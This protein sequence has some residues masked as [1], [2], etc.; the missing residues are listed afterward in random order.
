M[1]NKNQRLKE[2]SCLKKLLNDNCVKNKRDKIAT[3]IHDISFE[4]RKAD[5]EVNESDGKRYDE[6]MEKGEENQTIN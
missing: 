5:E 2:Q 4:R 6:S 1:T 3:W